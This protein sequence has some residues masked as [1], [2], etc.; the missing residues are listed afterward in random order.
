METYIS[1]IAAGTALLAVII[2]PI[3]SFKIAKRQ[4]SASTVTTSRQR[5][6]NDLRD[7]IADFNAKASMI[8]CLAANDY[9]DKDSIPR[10]EELVQINLKIELLINPGEKDHAKIVEIVGYITDSLFPSKVQENE[11]SSKLDSKIKEL[12]S[13]TQ[14]VL[15]REWE[16][17]KKG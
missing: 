3:V 8:H 6:I 13:L 12:T 5:W 11:I 1:I 16:R 17:V 4:I 15:K 10:I 2:G 14:K 7:A 9:A